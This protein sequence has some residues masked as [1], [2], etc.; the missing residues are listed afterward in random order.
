MALYVSTNV[1]LEQ[2]QIWSMNEL[3]GEPQ[4]MWG[5]MP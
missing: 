5:R 1:V 3:D 2:N 4:L